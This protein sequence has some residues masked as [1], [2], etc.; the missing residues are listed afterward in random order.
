MLDSF[1][2]LTCGAVR[3]DLLRGNTMRAIHAL[4]ALAAIILSACGGADDKAA[5]GLSAQDVAAEAQDVVKPEPGQYSST[6]E[7]LEFEI[8]GM[9]DA[10]KEQMKAQA[11]S[12]LAQGNSF[13]M[14]AEQ[15][16]PKTMV[17]NIAESD[18]TFNRFDVNGGTIKADMVCKGNGG[19]EGHVQMDG[20][21]TATGSVMTMAMQ[22]SMGNMGTVSMKMRVTSRRTGECS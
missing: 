13:C 6:V 4:P 7:L 3:R 15:A 2:R 17:Q 21:M 1:P 19:P 12:G 16:D 20:T 9:T 5:E 10:M 8:P 14:T 22:Q 18:C 11:Q